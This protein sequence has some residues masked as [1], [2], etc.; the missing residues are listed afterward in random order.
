MSQFTPSVG[1]RGLFNLKPPFDSQILPNTAY[2]VKAVRT[3]DDLISS[4][5]IDPKDLYYTHNGLDDQYDADVQDGVS[6][7]SLAAD[8]E[9]IYVPS[10]YI[11]SMPDQGGIPY[12]VLA[13]AVMLGPLA[14]SFDLSYLK[15]SMADLVQATIGITPG[16]VRTVALSSTTNVSQAEHDRIEAAR[17]ALITESD[18]DRAKL[19]AMT[20]ERDALAQKVQE[21]ETALLEQMA[22][23][24]SPPPAPAPAPAP[25]PAPGP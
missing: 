20:A 10:S 11:L 8:A 1:V 16:E 22:P 25:T 7:V 18:T 15:T 17:Q 6:I 3:L 21:L 9:W 13:L 24:P 19:L 4:S 12:T 14:D 23:P 2:E 5:G